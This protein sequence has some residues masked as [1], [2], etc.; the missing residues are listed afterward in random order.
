MRKILLPILL[1]LSLASLGAGADEQ[2]AQPLRKAGA[3]KPE[4]ALLKSM[5]AGDVACYLTLVNAR[6]EETTQMA[7]FA[8]C[9]MDA[10]IGRRVQIRRTKA[11]VMAES[12]QGNP[13]CTDTE[14]VNL[15]S[16]VK[17]LP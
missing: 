14:T 4:V 17:A 8:I 16:K 15:I 12:C 9:E 5:E 10:L 2:A 13:D 6:G 1:G 11:N 7:D 3:K